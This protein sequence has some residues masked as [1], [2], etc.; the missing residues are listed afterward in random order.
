MSE[1]LGSSLNTGDRGRGK[2]GEGRKEMKTIV[3]KALVSCDTV[4]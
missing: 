4:Y 1:P 2:W 3:T